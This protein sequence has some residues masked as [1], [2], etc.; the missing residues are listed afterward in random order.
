MSAI[1]GMA[2]NRWR[3]FHAPSGYRRSRS[4]T[5]RR[6]TKKKKRRINLPLVEVF[7]EVLED[8]DD[9]QPC[10]FCHTS[11]GGAF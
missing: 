7:D 1:R 11:P 3:N 8:E 5:K 4:G 6:W 10:F 2:K 9:D